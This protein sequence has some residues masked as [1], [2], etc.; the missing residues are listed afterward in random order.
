MI[1][2]KTLF[3]PHKDNN[4]Q[5]TFLEEMQTAWNADQIILSDDENYDLL[6]IFGKPTH[7]VIRN[8]KNEIARQIPILYSPLAEI[9]PWTKTLIDRSIA[10]HLFI[11]ATGKVEYAYIQRHYPTTKIFQ[12]KN[13]AVTNEITQASF[14]SCLVNM[15]QEILETH[16]KR[17]KENISIRIEKL[18]TQVEDETMQAV[19][20]GFLYLQY[21]FQRR[22][23]LQDELCNQ[24][25]LMETCDYDEDKMAAIFKELKLYKFVSCLESVMEEKTNLTEGFMPIPAVHNSLTNK[26]R[27]SAL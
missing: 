6:H 9:A 13:P 16:D 27:L 8:I 14:N 20:S 11:H 2:I 21:K 7:E 23:I 26:I 22:Q 10:K 25:R 3:T 18:K 12:L 15:Y 4:L 17:I 5:T 24:S 1:R 19:V